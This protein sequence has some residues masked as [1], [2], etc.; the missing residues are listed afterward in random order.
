[1]PSAPASADSIPYDTVFNV[2]DGY[3]RWTA[4]IVF[5]VFGLALVAVLVAEM[6]GWI[7]M[8]RPLRSGVSLVLL[9]MVLVLLPIHVLAHRDYAAMRDAMRAGHFTVVEGRV[10]DFHAPRR[11]NKGRKFPETFK[12]YSHKQTFRYSYLENQLAPGFETPSDRD[13]PI[14]EGL[15]V[16]IADIDGRIARLEIAPTGP[17][18]RSG[19]I[20]ATTQP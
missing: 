12:V 19:Y 11:L 16:R 20:G 2:L 13:G 8:P 9:A 1:M 5:M 6:R 4:E 3:P 15:Q 10:E 18:A 14:R 7:R 17:V